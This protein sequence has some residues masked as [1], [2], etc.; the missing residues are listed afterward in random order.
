MR[1]SVGPFLRYGFSLTQFKFFDMISKAYSGDYN[2]LTLYLETPCFDDPPEGALER[3]KGMNNYSI[4]L[5]LLVV[6]LITAPF[7]S[8]AM[9]SMTDSEMDSIIGQS[10]VEIRVVD[11]SVDLHIM[12]IAWADSD[13]G[14]LMVSGVPVTYG[15]GYV[16]I[17]DFYVK[18]LY[19]TMDTN[20][21]GI[22]SD[23]NG[24][25]VQYCAQPL[26]LDVMTSST[27]PRENTFCVDRGKTMLVI[28]VPDMYISA[29]VF[30]YLLLPP[31]F[32]LK[33]SD[34]ITYSFEGHTWL[35]GDMYLDDEADT[36]ETAK[37]QDNEKWDYTREPPEK[38]KHLINMMVS[39]V[40]L[41]LHAY[42][43]GYE[44]A[45]FTPGQSI[46]PFKPNHRAL[47]LLSTH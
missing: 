44:T 43:G 20:A 34:P 47:I 1:K 27:N 24:T 25:F 10:G 28:G 29:E 2:H 38:K 32:P 42:V 16:N 7:S 14:T 41:S 9:D 39:G 13:C 12:N 36:V 4:F 15:P 26:T 3:A 11:F 33:D 5:I 22:T 45:N 31:A 40:E 30:H 8:L 19:I 21:S 6:T 37:Y 35:G 23:A 17:K 46:H 18:N